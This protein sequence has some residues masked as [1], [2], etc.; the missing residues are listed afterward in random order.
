MR[1]A[2]NWLGIDRR[3]HTYLEAEKALKKGYITKKVAAHYRIVQVV[4]TYTVVN[5]FEV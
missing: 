4:T 2:R 1:W 3:F 5:T